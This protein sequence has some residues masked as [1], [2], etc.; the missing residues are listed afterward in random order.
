MDFLYKWEEGKHGHTSSWLISLWIPEKRE[1][2]SHLAFLDK[3]PKTSKNAIWFSF[4]HMLILV[5]RSRNCNL[6]SHQKNKWSHSGNVIFP[7]MLLSNGATDTVQIKA[8]G[9]HLSR[10][11]KQYK[12]TILRVW[13][14]PCY[15]RV[16]CV[17]G[18]QRGQQS[19]Q[20]AFLQVVI[21]WS[22]FRW[23]I[24]CLQ[25]GEER[26]WTVFQAEGKAKWAKTREGGEYYELNCVSPKFTCWS[27][28]TQYLRMWLYFGDKAFHKVIKL[29]WSLQDGPQSDLTG[30]S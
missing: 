12:R 10:G 1:A 8:T 21:L 14:M 29:K 20:E 7:R 22:S 24:A 4:S 23:C 15:S 18:A 30:F 19:S 13:S 11:D 9:I 5:A 6:M 26:V 28:K 16:Q 2:F 27:L 25:W 3:K 17:M